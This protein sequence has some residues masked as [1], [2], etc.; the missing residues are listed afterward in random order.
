MTIISILQKLAY[1]E[2]PHVELV[3]VGWISF[4]LINRGVILASA[5]Q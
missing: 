3:L 4:I 1:F 2:Q 5:R